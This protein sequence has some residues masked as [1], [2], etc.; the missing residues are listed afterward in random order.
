M[1]SRVRRAVAAFQSAP[2]AQAGRNVAHAAVNIP[3]A[4]EFQSAPGAQ[5]GRNEFTSSAV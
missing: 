5:A 4:I 2:G 3:S 1:R